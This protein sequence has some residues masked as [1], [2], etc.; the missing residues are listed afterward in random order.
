M[1]YY[2]A[3]ILEV[4]IN[5]RIEKNPLYMKFQYTSIQMQILSIKKYATFHVYVYEY[6]NIVVCQN[7]AHC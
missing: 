5:K 6:N 2:L 3:Y 4:Q 7:E 1:G